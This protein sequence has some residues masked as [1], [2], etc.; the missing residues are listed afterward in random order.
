MKKVLAAAALGFVSLCAAASMARAQEGTAARAGTATQTYLRFRV[1]DAFKG[2]VK[3]VRLERAGFVMRDG[4]RVEG[5]RVLLAVNRYSPDGRTAERE[6]YAPDGSLRRKTVHRYGNEGQLLEESHYDGGG[7]LV[8]RKSYDH[9]ADER[10]TFDGEGRLTERRVAVWNAR[11]DKIKEIL[12]Y[13]GAGA[14]VRREVNSVD[15]AGKKST[16]TAYD[17]EGKVVDQ[18]VHSLNYG[19]PH[20]TEQQAYNADGSAGG[21]RVATSDAAVT[22]LEAIETNA[23]GTVRRK[24]SEQREYDA[25]RNL[26]RLV[27]LRWDDAEGAYVPVAV[28]YYTTTYYEV[29]G[30]RPR[31]R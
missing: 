19:G 30:E 10:L 8:G 11:R 17:P 15:E 14:L 5:R 21:S 29:E 25:H 24:T 31:A 27:N 20:R 22:R 28:T 2:P 4:A 1:G 9:S 13:D 26:S 7:K 3:T 16:W 12:I 6:S 18:S 23:D